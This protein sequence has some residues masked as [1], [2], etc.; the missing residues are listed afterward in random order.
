MLKTPHSHSGHY[1]ACKPYLEK[2]A[3]TITSDVN[4]ANSTKKK[5]FEDDAGEEEKEG[6]EEEEEGE[7]EEEENEEEEKKDEPFKKEK[8][9]ALPK[10]NLEKPLP[11][12][13]TPSANVFSLAPAQVLPKKRSSVED[14]NEKKD[15]DAKRPRLTKEDEQTVNAM[16]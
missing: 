2:K 4:K 13:V 15:N 16:F 5:P 10:N 12:K 9:A 1:K 6:E 11:T 14:D 7:E 8:T 3:A